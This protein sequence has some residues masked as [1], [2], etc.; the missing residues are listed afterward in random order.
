MKVPSF[1]TAYRFRVPTR[2][3][4][5]DR[6][7]EVPGV[8]RFDTMESVA[9]IEKRPSEQR[10]QGWIDLALRKPAD[11]VQ[12]LQT[13]S[14]EMS[15]S[16]G[17]Q[18]AL[19]MLSRASLKEANPERRAALVRGGLTAF[20]HLGQS[21]LSLDNVGQAAN[22]LVRGSRSLSSDLRRGYLEAGLNVIYTRALGDGSQKMK[23]DL[24]LRGSAQDPVFL[25]K[26][27]CLDPDFEGLGETSRG[28]EPGPRV[29]Q[30]QGRGPL[31]GA[32][33]Q[34]GAGDL[35]QTTL[36]ATA[37]ALAGLMS[38]PGIFPNSLLLGASGLFP[39]MMD[40]MM[41]TRVASQSERSFRNPLAQLNSSGLIADDLRLQGF[42]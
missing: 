15:L 22:S 29:G 36:A 32:T 21:D 31:G 6:Q 11:F 28:S 18:K 17:Q 10:L 33:Q 13:N 34:S 40:G 8:D 20:Q 9:L 4:Q 38:V 16:R 5:P 37:G 1:Q 42:F 24:P 35:S 27:L 2:Y 23:L 30:T 7:Q 19:R 39:G 25:G 3:S 14:S 12:V 26:L 41:N